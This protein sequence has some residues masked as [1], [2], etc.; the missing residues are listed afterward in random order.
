MFL[1][2]GRAMNQENVSNNL[3]NNK[4]TRL[5]KFM[6]DRRGGSLF[7]EQVIE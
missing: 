4:I 6:K 1:E 5:I 2:Q 7:M 3:T